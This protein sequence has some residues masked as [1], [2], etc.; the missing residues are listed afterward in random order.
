MS[1]VVSLQEEDF[2]DVNFQWRIF[3]EGAMFSLQSKKNVKHSDFELVFLTR[4]KKGCYKY[5]T[6]IKIL[7]GGKDTPDLTL[8]CRCQWRDKN[9][10]RFG[11]SIKI[12]AAKG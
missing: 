4:E 10:I 8:V 7:L 12:Q 6:A 2:L 9:A 3:Y 11:L 5:F 1:V